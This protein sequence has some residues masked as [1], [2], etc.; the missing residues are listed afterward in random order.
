MFVSAIPQEFLV[1]ELDR[2]IDVRERARKKALEKKLNTLLKGR[3]VSVLGVPPLKKFTTTTKHTISRLHCMSKAM[4]VPAQRQ[5]S[6]ATVSELA[7]L[8]LIDIQRK[9]R[10]SIVEEEQR[11]RAMHTGAKK[12]FLNTNEKYAY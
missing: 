1:R 7:K 3:I 2:L 11:A 6:L 10:K 4:T 12:Y 8:R 5:D 9:M